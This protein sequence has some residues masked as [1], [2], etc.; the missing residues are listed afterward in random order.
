MLVLVGKH[1]GSA[2]IQP[3]GGAKYLF[4]IFPLDLTVF[5]PSIFKSIISEK[6]NFLPKFMVFLKIYGFFEKDRA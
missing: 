5:G 1:I 3:L 4:K 6:V 2:Y